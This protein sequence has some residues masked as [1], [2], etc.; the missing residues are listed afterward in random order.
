MTSNDLVVVVVV[1]SFHVEVVVVVVARWYIPASRRRIVPSHP[2]ST[3]TWKD[4]PSKRTADGT[5]FGGWVLQY[6]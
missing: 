6:E 5:R 3:R 2:S 1:A 4:G